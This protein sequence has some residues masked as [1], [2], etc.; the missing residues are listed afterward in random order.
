MIVRVPDWEKRLN[1]VVERHMDLP[2]QFGVSDCWMIPADAFEAITGEK[3][4]R[5]IRYKTEAGAAKQLRKRGFETVEDAF[6]ARLPE[7]GRL[8]ARRGDLGVVERDGAI[9][10]GV[11]TNI[12]FVTRGEGSVLILPITEIKTAFRVGD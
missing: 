10:G 3:L 4:Y 8:S 5:G 9:S 12:G 1:E 11:V 7:I 2:S 6:R